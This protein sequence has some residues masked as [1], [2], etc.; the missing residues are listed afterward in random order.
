MLNARN[1]FPLKLIVVAA[2]VAAPAFQ[3]VSGADND[4]KQKSPVLDL[5]A[6]MQKKLNAQMNGQI[7]S[8]EEG[9]AEAL[10]G[11]LTDRVSEK[12]AETA[13]Q[14]DAQSSTLT[15][16]NRAEHRQDEAEKPAPAEPEAAAATR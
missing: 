12:G 2:L 16:A 7:E 14:L 5:N 4:S 10:D 9:P 1:G 15:S 11:T 8:K 6:L 13:E 3:A